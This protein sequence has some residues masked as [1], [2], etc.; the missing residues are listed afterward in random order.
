L[1]L[2]EVWE[3][4]L[5]RVEALEV[6]V[7]FWLKTERFPNGSVSIALLLTQTKASD[8]SDIGMWRVI[9]VYWR[10]KCDNWHRHTMAHSYIKTTDNQEVAI[11]SQELR[12]G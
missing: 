3:K 1:I 4:Q 6:M 5:S 9:M 8:R 12:K 2:H 11:Q 7:I 10:R